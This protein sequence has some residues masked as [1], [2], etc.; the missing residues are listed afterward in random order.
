[1]DYVGDQETVSSYQNEK[2]NK[3]RLLQAHLG[4]QTPTEPILID[5]AKSLNHWNHLPMFTTTSWRTKESTAA[6]ERE[7]RQGVSMFNNM[8]MGIKH[9]DLQHIRTCTEAGHAHT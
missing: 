1:M 5:H 9:S 6:R 2:S 4:D 7:A 3:V 8:Y